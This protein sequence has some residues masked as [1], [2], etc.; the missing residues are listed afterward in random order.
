MIWQEYQLK[1]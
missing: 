1:F